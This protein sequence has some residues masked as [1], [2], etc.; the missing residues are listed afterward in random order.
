M[1]HGRKNRNA[2]GVLLGK[3]EGKNHLKA[4]GIDGR[5]G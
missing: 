2:Y 3:P 4:L 5:K 1:L